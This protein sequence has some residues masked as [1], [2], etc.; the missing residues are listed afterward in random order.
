M[1]TPLIT[2]IFFSLWLPAAQADLFTVVGEDG[3]ITITSTKKRGA[4]VLYR[5]GRRKQGQDKRRKP[6]SAKKVNGPKGPEVLGRSA[7][8]ARYAETVEFA[9]QE[10]GLPTALI[11]A[12]MKVESD[13]RPSV[14]SNKGAQGLMQ[15][16]PGTAGDMGVT[17]AFDPTQNILGGARYLRVLAN[18]FDGDM[19]LTLSGYHAG[20][21]AV[22]RHGGIPYD[23]TAEYVRR[24][25][26]AYY[27]YLQ[28]PPVKSK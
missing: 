7:R 12:V 26:N 15:L 24:V 10:Y 16:M 11:W 20:G 14:V 27:E 6:V 9:S 1:R 25:L 22:S 4:R 21:G 19:V 17:D 18:R 2:F 3:T 5:E 23:Q 13:F 28:A 8:A